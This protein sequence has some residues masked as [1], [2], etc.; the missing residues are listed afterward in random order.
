MSV[1]AITPTYVG[2][3]RDRVENFHGNQIVYVGWDRHLM[4]CSPVAFALPP[5]T[6]F[7]KLQDEIIPGAF[8]Q[9]PDFAQ[10]DWSAVVWH[11]NGA[12]FSPSR[13]KS[14]VEQGVDH[15]SII[16]MATPGLNG[17]KGSGS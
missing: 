12:P 9:H 15:K 13:D 8:S 3:R 2:E 11:L 14:L 7:S 10:I 4:F 6:P 17:I 16:R 1:A 5:E